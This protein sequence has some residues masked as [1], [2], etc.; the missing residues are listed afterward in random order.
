LD[1]HP[2]IATFSDC[3]LNE[4]GKLIE[5][6]VFPNPPE[7]PKKYWLLDIPDCIISGEKSRPSISL[8]YKVLT[9]DVGTET[10]FINCLIHGP[11]RVDFKD[12]S[13]MDPFKLSKIIIFILE[14]WKTIVIAIFLI[15]IVK[16]LWNIV[17]RLLSSQWELNEN[18]FGFLVFISF[19][20]IFAVW[21][22]S[23]LEFISGYSVLV[24]FCYLIVM[25][26]IGYFI[27]HFAS[28][29]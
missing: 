15:F 29:F 2:P 8:M 11:L 12:S 19:L 7:R 4:K 5:A 23:A 24:V 16:T 10:Y 1:H 20:L 18:V 26:L 21:A 13:S 3:D 9:Y 6:G 28:K 27:K 17:S 22:G 25:V 14:N